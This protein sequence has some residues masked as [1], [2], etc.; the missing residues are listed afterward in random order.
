MYEKSIDHI[1]INDDR[2]NAFLPRSRQD[3][4]IWFHSFCFT[5]DC[6][7]CNKASK[8]NVRYP[9][10]K[11]RSKTVLTLRSHD[12]LGRKSDEINKLSYWN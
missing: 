8:G 12:S 4:D 2:S 6:S 9:D 1:I 3:K 5:G 7:Q 11:E 10:G